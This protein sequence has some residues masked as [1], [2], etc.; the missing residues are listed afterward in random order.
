V[1]ITLTNEM[2]PEQQPKVN[3]HTHFVQFDPRPRTA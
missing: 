2:D 3:M 1:A